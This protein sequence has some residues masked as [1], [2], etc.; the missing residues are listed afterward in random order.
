MNDLSQQEI[1]ILLQLLEQYGAG[2]VNAGS[3]GGS[4]S[5]GES[6][7]QSTNSNPQAGPATATS[8]PTPGQLGFASSLTSMGAIATQ[9]PELGNLASVF[10]LA[11]SLSNPNASFGSV[12]PSVLGALGY[13]P[14]ASLASMANNG[15]TTSNVLGLLGATVNPAFGLIGLAN[16]ISGGS[17]GNSFGALGNTLGNTDSMSALSDAGVSFGD[18]IG[19]AMNNSQF[20][21]DTAGMDSLSASLSGDDSES[22][23]SSDSES[24]G[25]DSGD[26]GDSE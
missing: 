10:G 9:S 24:G 22:D 2:T 1:L 19:N 5:S 14:A 11:S 18:Q 12:A 21:M 6:K 8:A 23:S 3:S 26:S 4:S 17:I 7:T 16:S 13:G 25:S 15:F 20:G